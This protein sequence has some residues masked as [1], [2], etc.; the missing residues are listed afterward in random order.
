MGMTRFV[1]IRQVAEPLTSD[2]E[3]LSM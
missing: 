3:Y 2:L 1:F